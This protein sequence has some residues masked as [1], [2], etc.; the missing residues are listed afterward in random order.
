M[1]EGAYTRRPTTY[2][3]VFLV[4]RG[5]MFGRGMCERN[6]GNTQKKRRSNKSETGTMH[7]HTL[8]AINKH[9]ED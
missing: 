3:Y 9:D 7:T 1:L 8:K 2:G 4:A 6:V 5:V